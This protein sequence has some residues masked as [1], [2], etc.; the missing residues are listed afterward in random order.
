[1][2]LPYEEGGAYG[3]GGGPSPMGGG[4]MY[5]DNYVAQEAQEAH[6]MPV[7]GSRYELSDRG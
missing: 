5:N 4:G 1:M 2:V 6:E 7:E 3:G